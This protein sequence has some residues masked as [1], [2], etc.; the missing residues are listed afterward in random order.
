MATFSR[1]SALI[2]ILLAAGAFLAPGTGSAS[3]QGAGTAPIIVAS[4]STARTEF[5]AK[6][7][8]YL[9]TPYS[10]G[11]DTRAGMDCSG[12]VY[13][14]FYE[15][16]GWKLPRTV[17][18][19]QKWAQPVPPGEIEPGDLVFFTISEARP[20][21]SSRKADHVGI[22]AGQGR[23][24]HAASEGAPRG[25]RI[26]SLE[27]EYWAQRRLGAGRALPRLGFL[28]ILVDLG[29]EGLTGADSTQLAPLPGR[30]L[31]GWAIR[32][33][34]SHHLVGPFWIGV[35]TRVAQDLLM[36][37]VRI[38]LELVISPSRELDLFV[39]P[40]LTLGNPVL[41]AGSAGNPDARPYSA[42]GQWLATGGIRW[43]PFMARAGVWQVGLTL[44]LRYDRYITDAL[45]ADL[46]AADRL[47]TMTAG[48][49]LRLR[50]DR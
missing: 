46:P 16:T 22:Y 20:G 31:R 1:V 34:I 18:T 12:L 2:R 7:E 44:E 40:A 17:A 43:S 14:A 11:G 5:V 15:S 27:D 30:L 25:V 32:A 42:S 33:G 37:V 21:E 6:A 45:A 48:I 49:G 24:V 10:L 28:G 9:G 35:E 47:A 8:S 3:A 38:P 4:A 41:P 13:R 19:L 39:G 29:V 26:S 50:T 23:F 36:N